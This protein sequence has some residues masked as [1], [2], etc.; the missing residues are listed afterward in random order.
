MTMIL[1]SAS[2]RRQELL[3][4]VG[5]DFKVI[6]SDVDEDNK[7]SSSPAELAVSLAVAKALDVAKKAAADDVVLGADTIVVMDGQVYGKPADDAD[8]CRML[9]ELAGR[10]HQVITGIA[11][12][13]AGRVWTD[14]A[15]TAVTFRDL[16]RSEIERY[17]A[18]GEP[19]DKAGSYAIQGIGA[20]FV[21]GIE[22]CYANVV[23]LPLV[24]LDKLLGQALGVSLLEYPSG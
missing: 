21:E 13:T 1:A 7:W 23:G 9:G 4:Q 6:A 8:A 15:V 17:V 12:A 24:T 10:R 11:V 22:G 3:R 19:R 16:T 20:L 14:F 18:S 5:C 2:P